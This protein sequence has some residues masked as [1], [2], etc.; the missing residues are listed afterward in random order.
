MLKAKIEKITT[1]FF[2]KNPKKER[3]EEKVIL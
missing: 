2:K 3:G 1:I